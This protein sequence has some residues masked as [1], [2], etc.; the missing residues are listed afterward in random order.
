MSGENS[1][2]ISA[3]A[4]KFQLNINQTDTLES[5]TFQTMIGLE[6]F[7][8]MATELQSALGLPSEKIAELTTALKSQIFNQLDAIKN[9]TTKDTPDRFVQ[10]PTSLK[11]TA[12]EAPSSLPTGEIAEERIMG[13]VGSPGEKLAWEQRKQIAINALPKTEE[14]K[15]GG[16]DPYREPLQ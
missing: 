1:E 13:S 16:I 12:P 4:A 6:S 2:I 15:Y 8:Q 14:N 9:G 7:K 10:T 3:L 5:E 11:S